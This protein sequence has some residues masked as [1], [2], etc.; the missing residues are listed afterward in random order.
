MDSIRQPD[1]LLM[2]S[3]EDHRRELLRIAEEERLA[4]LCQPATLFDR[5]VAW[6][7]GH[8][9]EETPRPV[10]SIVSRQ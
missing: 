6:L 7:N 5:M 4:R 3:S 8:Q 1:W 9:L 10:K 2:A